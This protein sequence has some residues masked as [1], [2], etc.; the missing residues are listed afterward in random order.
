M[1]KLWISLAS[2][3]AL[4]P[5]V[6]A[7]S[8]GGTTTIKRQEKPREFSVENLKDFNTITADGIEWNRGVAWHSFSQGT[9]FLFNVASAL[10]WQSAPDTVETK[11]KVTLDALQA[12]ALTKPIGNYVIDPAGTD[13]TLDAK[14]IQSYGFDYQ[15][16]WGEYTSGGSF[17]NPSTKVEQVRMRHYSTFIDGSKNDGSI[18][19]KVWFDS[20]PGDTNSEGDAIR[21]IKTYHS[22]PGVVRTYPVLVDEEINNIA[23]NVYKAITKVKTLSS[24]SFGVTGPLNQDFV[25]M[26]KFINDKANVFTQDKV[27]EIVKKLNNGSHHLEAVMTFL[28]GIK[29]IP[30]DERPYNPAM[31]IEGKPQDF[32]QN[33]ALNGLANMNELSEIKAWAHYVDIA[34]HYSYTKN[35]ESITK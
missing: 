25:K 14:F 23:T 18:I 1:K 19:M 17:V 20:V 34:D 21:P 33:G 31:I 2:L 5:I 10:G 26:L 22:M 8:C 27:T 16:A 32:T 30:K 29:N 4:A 6:A 3:S 12:H 9:S 28:S 24:S 13:G 11:Q 7:V 35:A 15:P